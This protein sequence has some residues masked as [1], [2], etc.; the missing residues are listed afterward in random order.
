MS[1]RFLS[2]LL[3]ASAAVVVL[4]GTAI[5]PAWADTPPQ[6]LVDGVGAGAAGLSGG[7]WGRSSVG[8]YLAGRHAEQQQDLSRAADFLIGA[9]A[10][11]P[12]HAS[13]R[14]RVFLLLLSEG[15]F[16]ESLRHA[17][18]L[19]E[20]PSDLPVADLALAIESV[21]AGDYDAAH[22]RIVGLSEQRYGTFL[23]PAALAWTLLG[24]GDV[25][26]ALAELE[27]MRG[28]DGFEA[29]YYLHLGL[30]ADVAG[31]DAKADEAFDRLVG[32]R[33]PSLRV[34]QLAGNFWERTGNTERA[35]ALYESYAAS[36]E[37]T[38][39]I[40]FRVADE[41]P[42]AHIATASQG[43]G[44]VMFNIAGA[45][46]E[47]RETTVALIYSRLAV[48]LAPDDAVV[49]VLVAEILDG[50]GRHAAAAEAYRHLI[51]DPGL[52]RL[53]TLRYARNLDL[54]DQTDEALEAL[55]A[56]A[57]ARPDDPEP[58]AELGHLLR[59][60]SRF[61][62]AVGAYDHAIDSIDTIRHRHWRLL[63][64]RGIALERS[65]QWDRAERDLKAAL[66]FE[67]DQPYVLNYLGY[68]WADQ[69]QHLDKAEGM[70]RR[71]VELRPEDGFITDSLG[72][73]YYRTGRYEQAVE[74]LERAVELEPLD[75]VINDH[76]GDAY[77]KVG[78]TREARFQ[79][80]R[81]L[82]MEPEEQLISDIRRKVDCGLDGC[83]GDSLRRGG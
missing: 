59:R 58:H 40:E 62:E 74:W 83:P 34:A 47:D 5:S 28:R 57:A 23:R 17:R 41:P 22:R 66:Q 42:A 8:Q 72:W 16:D 39:P 25:D 4:V 10:W 67:P 1:K 60:H 45:L 81:A 73:V 43:L 56:L 36:I 75:P 24:A 78:R 27:S 32:L 3:G 2:R 37:T 15:R 50:Q 26:G 31:D 38:P 46:L 21:R 53:A 52:G 54:S 63:Y 6:R 20:R 12:D 49:G 69:G 61:E 30:L 13:L 76:L 14:R 35:R 33:T 7:P 77:W 11:E 65:G 82:T 64:S 9:L 29:L 19:T 70:I 68:S 48:T 80:K 18:I 51:D 44:E 55:E 71:A 79:W